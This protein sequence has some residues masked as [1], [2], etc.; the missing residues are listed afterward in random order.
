MK[1]RSPILYFIL[2]L[3]TGGLFGLLWTFLMARDVNAA[4]HDHIRGLGWLIVTCALAL[5]GYLYISNYLLQIYLEL[6]AELEAGRFIVL[7][8]VGGAEAL[9][10]LFGLYVSVAWLYIV[11]RI[12][13]YL[14]ERQVPV[15]GN[16]ALSLLF[17]LFGVAFP[18]LQSRLNRLAGEDPGRVPSATTDR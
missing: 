14:R 4:K 11:F 18:M 3:V 10:L 13:S 17:L 2:F 12:A 1:R 8:P 9:A 5:A 7:P 16:F 6:L 15:P